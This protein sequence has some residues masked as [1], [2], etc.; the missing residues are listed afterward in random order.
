MGTSCGGWYAKVTA[1][2]IALLLFPGEPANLYTDSVYMAHIFKP[3]ET[4][5]YISPT[6]KVNHLLN[7]VQY[8]MWQRTEPLFVGHIHSHTRQ[9]RPL[10]ASNDLADKYTHVCFTSDCA[11]EIHDKFHLNAC[12]LWHHTRCTR[13]VA[14]AITSS[15]PQ[16]APFLSSPNLGVNPQGLR[17]NQLWQMDIIYLPATGKLK[18]VHVSVDTFSGVIFA[19]LHSGERTKDAIAHCLSA[20]VNIGKPEVI[21]TDNGPA[22]ISKKFL[23]FC[24][25]YEISHKTGIPYNPMDQAIIERANQTLKQYFQKIKRGEFIFSPATQS[26]S[27]LFFKNF[28][29][30]C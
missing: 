4:S 14:Q 1:C 3:L 26:S 30:G 12:S 7:C 8:L 16:C 17:T 10:S 25:F 23:S 21:K 11:Q 6:F 19:S 27:I 2:V 9:P 18:F 15:C 5:A 20:F 28:D 29:S 22:Y 24:S 13:E